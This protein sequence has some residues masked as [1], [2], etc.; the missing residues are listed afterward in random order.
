MANKRIH[1][2]IAILSTAGIFSNIDLHFARFISGFSADPHPDTFLAA[3][4]V[5]RS[6]ASG[7]ICLDLGSMSGMVLSE[8]PSVQ[9]PIV[10]PS[11]DKWCQNLKTH[12]A[13]GKPGDRRPLILDDNH[14]LYLYRYWQ[15]ETMLSSSI[16]QR[17]AGQLTDFDLRRV[18]ASLKRLFPIVNEDVDWQ[19]VAA[20]IALFKRFSII[21][22]GPGSGKTH[23]IA[24]ILA[25]LLEC[26]SQN[27]LDIC[28]AAP[29][30]KAAARLGESILQA[31][32]NLNCRRA[33]KDGIPDEVF[34]I[35]RLL[36]P[37][38]GTPY[39]RYNTD[40][41]LPADVVVVDEASMVD[42][43]LMSKL[44]QAIG[45]DTRLLIAG[46]QNQL[47]SVEAGSVLG[48]ICDRQV[49]HGFS[50]AFVNQLA[51]F[52][53]ATPEHFDRSPDNGSA[54][55]DCICMLQKNYRFSSQSGI[56][57]ISR[58][59]NSGDGDKSM[60]LLKNPSETA[61]MWNA[62]DT[63][64]ELSRRLVPM[65][66]EGYKKY[67][68]IK[69]PML[70]MVAFNEFK[71]LC[72]LKIGPFG[73]K[74]VNHLAEQVLSRENLIGDQ[75][76]TARPW[77]RGRPVM[78]TQNSYKLGLYN[79]DIGITYSD[80][81][82]A[83]DPLMVYFQDASGSVR[84]FLPQRLPE[85]ETVYAMTVHKSQGSEFNHVL[86]IL[87]DK[88]YPLL[89]RELIYTGLTRARQKVT[90]WGTEPIV[91]TTISRRIERSSGLREA[92]WD[93]KVQGSGFTV[94]G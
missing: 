63:P 13:V 53:G 56:G 36:Q 68:T 91:R 88:D 60:A 80:P 81:E 72:A 25:F 8:E 15:Y 14:R 90:I 75:S 17:A 42:L 70:A 89:T 34:T 78:I 19:K 69:D 58:A 10:C 3:A 38:S 85:H 67:L 92:L 24:G 37:L 30:G 21:T 39:F 33:V 50:D 76:G 23:A 83:D 41:I 40:N 32:E 1:G 74:A 2:F 16:R 18:K 31:K 20:V 61:V 54:L 4:L 22:G 82:N 55:Q 79:G 7:D 5:S 86:L 52:T 73:A 66:I 43:A 27:K 46:D 45:P 64:E 12:P 26:S 47:A 94:Q 49:I 71:I 44:L 28:L 57:G 93:S 6:T 62:I 84:R 87:P 65:I 29:T 77:Y 35:H 9:E 59:I 11:L 48:D 51:E